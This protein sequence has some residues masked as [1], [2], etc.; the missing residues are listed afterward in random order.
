MKRIA[1]IV[2]AL[3]LLTCFC[4][5]AQAAQADAVPYVCDTALLL[6]D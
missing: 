6:T 3:A 1:L 5:P 2:C 4:I